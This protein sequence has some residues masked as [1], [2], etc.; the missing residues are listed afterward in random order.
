V[1]KYHSFC[2]K[3]SGV[4]VLDVDD[5]GLFEKETGIKIENLMETTDLIAVS[6]SGGLH[7]FYQY[8]DIPTL[9]LAHSKG[10]DLKSDK[11]LIT[12]PPS[13]GPVKNKENI[14]GQYVWLKEGEPK[15][16]P[17]WLK[18]KLIGDTIP[19]KAQEGFEV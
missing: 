14:W 17:D 4:I 12:L 8:E 6:K 16:L 19:K 10:F 7:F 13:I 5:L 2:G 18:E 11:S 3:A 9:L 1:I 15:R